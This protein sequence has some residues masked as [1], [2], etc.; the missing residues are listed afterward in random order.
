MTGLHGAIGVAL[1]LAVTAGAAAG[2]RLPVQSSISGFVHTT[3]KEREGLPGGATYAI[4]QTADGYLWLGSASGLLRFDGQ[5]FVRWTPF[6]RPDAMAGAV[7]A[8]HTGRDGTLWIGLAN[9]RVGRMHSG[10]IDY[11]ADDAPIAGS[12]STVVDAA[13]GTVWLYIEPSTPRP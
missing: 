4:T 8:V 2:D 9:G 11:L 7:T 13:D 1:A 3:W 6:G 12:G 5:R 10:G